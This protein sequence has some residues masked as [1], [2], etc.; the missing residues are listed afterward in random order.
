ME[1]NSDNVLF[2]KEKYDEEFLRRKETWKT[3]KLIDIKKWIPR[4]DASKIYMKI[5]QYIKRNK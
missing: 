1:T 2:Y 3:F 5:N 4:N